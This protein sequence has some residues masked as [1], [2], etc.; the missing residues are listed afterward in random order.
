MSVA[1]CKLSMYY[2]YAWDRTGTDLT[3][4]NKIVKVTGYS[5]STE[6]TSIAY[7]NSAVAAETSLFKSNRD[8]KLT[9]TLMRPDG[10]KFDGSGSTGTTIF[11]YRFGSTTCD[12]QIQSA[13]S[14]LAIKYAKSS[15]SLEIK[16]AWTMKTG[17]TDCANYFGWKLAYAGGAS[18]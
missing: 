7:T 8:Y 1:N 2:T 15:P 11:T 6:S 5:E 14:D 17:K 10:T 16:W 3:A 13:G 18:S 4:I 12:D 9:L